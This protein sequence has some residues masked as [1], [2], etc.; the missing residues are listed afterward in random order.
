MRNMICM[1][2]CIPISL[3]FIRPTRVTR[4]HRKTEVLQTREMRTGRSARSISYSH[5]QAAVIGRRKRLGRRMCIRGIYSPW[6][7]WDEI[8]PFNRAGIH[9]A[10][11]PGGVLNSEDGK[12]TRPRRTTYDR[13]SSVACR[14]P[15]SVGSYY[16]YRS[17]SVQKWL[18]PMRMRS[19]C[20]SRL[21]GQL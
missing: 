2:G 3:E 8:Y 15:A 5:K 11:F 9:H 16:Q 20:Y 7:P 21:D 19:C 14:R 4:R 10:N 18:P 6:R 1:Y 13:V 17:K 12:Q